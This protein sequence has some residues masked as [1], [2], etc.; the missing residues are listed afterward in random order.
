M[1][2]FPCE[3]NASTQ[4]AISSISSHPQAARTIVRRASRYTSLPSDLAPVDTGQGGFTH[5]FVVEFA[6]T[7][8]RDYYAFKDPVHQAFI[9]SI[10][11]KFDD[12]KVIDYEVGVY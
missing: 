8:D 7:E 12:L 3:K 6:S 5:G 4:A 1:T 2:C 10:D 11:G 9:K